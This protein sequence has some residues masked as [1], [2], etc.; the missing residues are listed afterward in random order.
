MNYSRF[1]LQALI[2]TKQK[3]RFSF[4]DWRTVTPK[5]LIRVITDFWIDPQSLINIG[6]DQDGFS[7]FDSHVPLNEQEKMHIIWRDWV[8]AIDGGFI[9]LTL[10]N[11]DGNFKQTV[12]YYDARHAKRWQT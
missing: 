6:N 7:D 3:S 8:S 5:T 12:V 10:W 4:P 1:Y 2:K 11:V 9:G